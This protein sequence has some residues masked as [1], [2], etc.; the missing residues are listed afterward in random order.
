[1]EINLLESILSGVGGG[2]AA[3]LFGIML[4]RKTLCDL[5]SRIDRTDKDLK[6]CRRNCDM[7]LEKGE[8]EFRQI[9]SALNDIKIQIARRDTID[10]VRSSFTRDII[11]EFLD[12]RNSPSSGED[13][14]E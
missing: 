1:M 6:E 2:S 10:S 7:R 4:L 3:I 9:I 14:F 11:R 13:I 5:S 12:K 8:I